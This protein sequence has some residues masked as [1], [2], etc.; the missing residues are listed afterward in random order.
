[1]LKPKN[2]YYINNSNAKTENIKLYK[3]L[4]KIKC[5]KI[6]IYDSLIFTI[7]ITIELYT[8]YLVFK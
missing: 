2:I 4:L 6:I 3:R 5:E 8:N 7:I 1:M